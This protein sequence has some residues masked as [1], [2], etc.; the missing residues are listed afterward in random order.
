MSETYSMTAKCDNCSHTWNVELPKG[1]SKERCCEICPYCGCA[2][3]T[4]YKMEPFPHLA[5]TGKTSKDFPT[6]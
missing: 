3:N 5:P 4:F 1:K 6:L 2:T